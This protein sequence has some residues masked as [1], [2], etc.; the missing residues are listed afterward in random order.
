MRST[1]GPHDVH[2]RYRL[3][4]LVTEKMHAQ[5]LQ[6]L[7]PDE[8]ERAARFVFPRDRL[9]FVAAHDLLR[10]TLSD[11]AD[12]PPEAWE[13]TQASSGKPLL[14]A[15]HR[16][17]NIGFNLAHT[18][19]LVACVVCRNTDVGIDVERLDRKIRALDLAARYF[20]PTE[21]VALQACTEHERHFRFIELWTLKESYVKAI[22]EGLSH[23]L[24]T[25]SFGF[26]GSSALR[27]D[28]PMGDQPRWQFE[29]FAPSVQHRMAVAVRCAQQETRQIT[30]LADGV[31]GANLPVVRT[32][33]RAVE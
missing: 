7:S 12:V 1:L 8:R 28:P 21:V 11:Y 31:W 20:S 27:F 4:E 18:R 19:G 30:P 25:F 24:H 13:F 29:L 17:I 14:S 2:A 16:G 32:S 3:T 26:D 6:T 10:R 9:M 5:A 15:R 22:G 23:P 33:V